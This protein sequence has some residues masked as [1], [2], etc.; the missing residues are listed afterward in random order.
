VPAARLP[1][2]GEGAEEG[3][4]GG[5]TATRR[6]PSGDGPRTTSHALCWTLHHDEF[7]PPPG[8]V[9]AQQAVRYLADQA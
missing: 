1:D 3:E 8:R 9:A 4:E 7:R 2:G 6:P 5:L